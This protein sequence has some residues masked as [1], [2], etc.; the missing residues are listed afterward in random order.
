MHVFTELLRYKCSTSALYNRAVSGAQS[1]LRL[2]L[3]A[4]CWPTVWS[5]WSRWVDVIARTAL[6]PGDELLLDYGSRPLRDFLQGYAFTPR[7][8][9][10]EVSSSSFINPIRVQGSR[11]FRVSSRSDAENLPSV[12]RYSTTWEAAGNRCMSRGHHRCARPLCCLLCAA[13]LLGKD[14]EVGAARTG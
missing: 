12:C 6:Q 1:V 11:T 9:A 7:N 14:N 10:N 5:A 3:T 4:T 2:I 8:C 13:P